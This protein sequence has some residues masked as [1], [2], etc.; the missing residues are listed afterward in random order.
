MARTCTRAV[1]EAA[2][3]IAAP[4][5]RRA[6]LA[7]VVVLVAAV[8]ALLAPLARAGI[9]TPFELDAAD[10]GR[11]VAVHHL[12]APWLAAAGDPAAAP[13]LG[14]LG[15][16]ELPFSSM[17]AAFRLLGLRAWVGRLPFALF[18]LVAVTATWAIAARFTRGR[19]A[20]FAVAVL[21]TCPLF[22]LHA[23]TMLGD[24]ATIACFTLAWAGLVGASLERR[25]GAALGWAALAS[26]GLAG[27][28]LCRGALLGVATPLAAVGLGTIAALPVLP[29]EGRRRRAVG[30]AVALVVSAGFAVAFVLAAAPVAAA[31]GAEVLRQVGMTLGGAADGEGTFDRIARQIGHA[32]FPW[33]ALAPIAVGCLLSPPPAAIAGLDDVGAQAR[34]SAATASA[35]RVHVLSVLAVSFLAV[36]ALVPWAGDLPWIG[37]A[38]LALAVALAVDDVA[39]D[40]SPDAVAGVVAMLLAG[41]FTLDLVRD[42]E[43]VLAALSVPELSF[44]PPLVETTRV[45]VAATALGVVLPIGVAWT[46]PP[47]DRSLGAHRAAV[48]AAARE[49]LAAWDGW[50]AF[51]LV[52]IEAALVGTA[53]MVFVGRWLEWDTV[54]RLARPTTRAFLHAWWV[55]PVGLLA[56]PLGLGA[57]RLALARVAARLR[58][59]PATIALGLSAAAALAYSVEFHGALAAAMSPKEAL[60]AYEARRDPGEPLGLLGLSPRLALF[61]GGA[62]VR[63]F[64]APVDAARWLVEAG[65]GPR[66]WLVVPGRD[67]G[68]LNALHRGVL[69]RNVPIADA[70]GESLLAVS[71]LRGAPERS[72][73]ADVVLDAAASP[74]RVVAANLDDTVELLGWEVQTVDGAV[75]DEVS[76]G[77]TYRARF[78]VRSLAPV[79]PSYRPFL[80]VERGQ[81][82]WNGD[83]AFVDRGYPSSLWRAGD[84]VALVCDFTLDPNFGPGEYDVWFGFF[85]GGARL[86]VVD[87]PASGD[88]VRMGVLRVR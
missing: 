55:A 70:S 5:E 33:S 66:R 67:L 53:A 3:P 21:V 26:L 65:A 34:R 41:V 12:A 42:P 22:A 57:A 13:T 51:I 86:E 28:Y 87:G 2:R 45:W 48:R 75:V 81:Q 9:L 17:A 8:V 58:A 39:R 68:K 63:S 4:G 59:E 18:G 83:D 71:D 54:V 72:P 77:T 76:A 62:D 37:A 23:R 11:R 85:A 60:V 10:L 27:G 19:V 40:A 15:M 35:L 1:A 32:A 29:R 56:L 36:S 74:A 24:G 52:V 25:S 61:H 20:A 14:D 43:R 46:G 49:A 7:S 30:A 38:P 69:G 64:N 84:V 80:H 31:R 47:R 82:R 6:R 73:L 50:L 88:R 44:P 79:A 78:L 16:G